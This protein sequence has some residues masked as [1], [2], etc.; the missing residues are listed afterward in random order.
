MLRDEF[1]RRVLP[2]ARLYQR[3]AGFFASSV[4]AAAP[5]E[6]LEFFE[7]GGRME[8]VCSP[9]L[10]WPD[11]ETCS[12]SLSRPH[13]WLVKPAPSAEDLG[14]KPQILLGWALSRGLLQIRIATVRSGGEPGL[15]HEKFGMLH[16]GS[17]ASSAFTGSA[18]ETGSAYLRNFESV[19]L[20]RGSDNEDQRIL[21]QFQY[22]FE[23]LWSNGTQGL[24]VVPLH[25]ALARNILEIAPS[26]GLDAADVSP[27]GSVLSRPPMLGEIL[28]LPARLSLGPHQ[29]DA[30]QAWFKAGGKGIYAMATSSGKTIAALATATRVFQRTGGPFVVVVVAP[31]LAL[32][33]QWLEVMQRFGLRPLR[34]AES[35]SEWYPRAKNALLLANRGK[36]AVVS[37]VATNRTFMGEPFQDILRRLKVRTL[38][39][40]DEVHNLGASG[41]RQALPEHVSL[42]LG[43]S[44]T[45]ERRW[46]TDGTLALQ[47][48]FGEP[49]IRFGLAE[50]L[51]AKPTVLSPYVYHPVL[52]DLDADEMEEYLRLTQSIARLMG[53]SGDPEKSELAFRLLIRRARLIGA[54]RNKL[55]ALRKVMEGMTRTEF[56]LVYCGDGR[57]EYPEELGGG[58]RYRDPADLHDNTV[59]RQVEAAVRLLGRDLKMRVAPY[60][61]ET[62]PEE[63]VATLEAFREGR[64]QALVA[65]RCL[66]E[67]VDIPDVRRA[68]ILASSTNPRQFIQRRGRVLR[69]S[70]GKLQAEIFDFFV[71][72]PGDQQFDPGGFVAEQRLVR[73]EMERAV[74]FIELARNS[75]DARYALLPL[76]TKMHLLDMLAPRHRL[77]EGTQ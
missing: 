63:R 22:D 46:D 47:E 62:P 35:A 75:V 23:R 73:R 7:S 56:N 60:T 4:F 42:R 38:L 41:L 14:R 26:E 74:D 9:R 36:R 40:A 39:I 64:L 49:V 68:F 53:P 10:G 76:L 3:A 16:Y 45:H 29:E 65:I 71:I 67:G 2:G 59:I 13:E 21:L 72:P 58:A 48:Y 54:A 32:V 6:F 25:E 12:D 61:Y 27:S 70:E 20:F 51:R 37:F 66:D 11:I 44:A 1:L 34:C 77:S 50:A 30:I 17:G 8:L 15:Y 33:D 69:R 57:S 31:F 28:A 24:D 55:V 19:H 18:N 43:L 5:K 52:V